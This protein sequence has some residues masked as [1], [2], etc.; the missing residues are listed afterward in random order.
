MPS[1]LLVRM[2]GA[3]PDAAPRWLLAAASA[4]CDPADGARADE[5]RPFSVGPLVPD[6]GPNATGLGGTGLGGRGDAGLAGAWEPST[7]GTPG[8]GGAVT[9]WRLGWLADDAPLPGWQPDTVRFGS[10]VLPVV[11]ADLHRY[12]YAELAQGRPA[13]GARLTMNTPTFFSRDGRDLPLPDPALAIGGL[14]ARWNTY[15]PGP[16]RI[17]A[18]DARALVEAVFLDGV[19]GASSEVELGHGLRQVGFVGQA[20]L[21]LLAATSDYTATMFAALA[22]F[23][24]FAGVGERTAHGFGAVDVDVVDVVD[25]VRAPRQMAPVAVPPSRRSGRAPVSSPAA[26]TVRR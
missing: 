20:D 9:T 11:G 13:R 24:A 18:D 1:I 5:A 26:R 14:L 3:I 17:G 25:V 6:A 10:Q 12:S 2:A 8:R 23:A 4:I 21:R 19:W 22:R 16:L 15:A 7:C